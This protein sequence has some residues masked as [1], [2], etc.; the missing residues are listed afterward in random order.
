[1]KKIK[2]LRAAIILSLSLFVYACNN[3]GYEIETEDAGQTG[4]TTNNDNPNQ[5]VIKNTPTED[6]STVTN[7][8]SPKQIPVKTYT[9]QIGAFTNEL[10]AEKFSE[11]AKT[12]LNIEINSLKIGGW[13][14]IKAGLFNSISDAEAEL[15]KVREEGYPD[16]FISETGK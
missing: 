8:E 1:M 12:S 16:S 13:I 6:N 3:V 4:N 9:I 11:K 10:S 14:K 7:N 15:E 2:I 5:Q